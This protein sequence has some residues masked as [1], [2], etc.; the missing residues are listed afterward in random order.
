[1]E[2]TMYVGRLLV[3]F[4]ACLAL[5]KIACLEGGMIVWYLCLGTNEP[6]S[7][8]MEIKVYMV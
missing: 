4:K 8:R 3:H 2:T 5:A 7:V 1:M 6:E